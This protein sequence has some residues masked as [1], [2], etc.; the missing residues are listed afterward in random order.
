MK[1]FLLFLTLGL[2]NIARYLY[3]QVSNNERM[4]Q[5][6]LY[7]TLLFAI[8]IGFGFKVIAGNA[9]K[10]VKTA[11]SSPAV[12]VSAKVNTSASS[13]GWLAKKVIGQ[14]N[15]K[16]NI[17]EGSVM[18]KNGVLAGGDFI[19]DMKSITC[20]DLTDENYNKKL[21]GHL[22]STDFF[23]VYEFP[24]ASLKI[25][26]VLKLTNKIN[27][28]NLTGDLTIKGITNSIT[29]PATFKAV[30]KVFEGVAKITID[31]TL[32]D[33][34]YGS[35]NFFEGLGDKA[36]KNEVELNVSFATN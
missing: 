25:T 18:T 31:R 4:K 21:I 33:I 23:N 5:K 15:G 12:L 10:T 34:K 29:F 20:D 19:I 3:L 22:N 30:G 36:I 26:K 27:S 13:I 8:T 17:Q 6:F 24:T 7:T 2:N 32:W 28:Y 14:H 35:T 9:K 11:N 16:V 1:T